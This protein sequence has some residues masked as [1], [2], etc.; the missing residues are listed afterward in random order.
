MSTRTVYQP[1]PDGPGALITEP[2]LVEELRV[3][4]S[5]RRAQED[6][7]GW[8]AFKPEL[9]D[10]KTF[11]KQGSALKWVVGGSDGNGG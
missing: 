10:V 9:Q 11:F 8:V 4:Y 7:K 6:G 1:V 5:E 2:P 3:F